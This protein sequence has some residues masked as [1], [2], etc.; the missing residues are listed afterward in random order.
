MGSSGGLI[1]FTI[2]ELSIYKST[3]R[4]GFA[5]TEIYLRDRDTHEIVHHSG[6]VEGSTHRVSKTYFFV[7]ETRES[8]TER[9]E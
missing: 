8:D 9:L 7:F 3:R 5:K 6:P 2:P 4:R 1:P